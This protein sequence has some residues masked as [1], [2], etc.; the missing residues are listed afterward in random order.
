MKKF[1]TAVASLLLLVISGCKKDDS[2]PDLPLKVEF[3][4]APLEEIYCDAAVLKVWVSVKNAGS[5]DIKGCFYYG[6]SDEDLATKG[7]KVEP[8]T[9]SVSDGT[10]SALV[11]GLDS[12]TTY[13]Y[14]AELKI[15]N[16]VFL[17]GVSSFNTGRLTISVTTLPADGVDYVEATLR[18]KVNLNSK[19]IVPTNCG[20]KISSNVSTLDEV[21]ALGSQGEVEPDKDNTFNQFLNWFSADKTYHYVAFAEVDGQTYYGELVDFTTKKYAEVVSTVTAKTDKPGFVELLGYIN[22]DQSGNALGDGFLF[23]DT[24]TDL[25]SLKTS[26]TDI[27]VNH[28]NASIKQFSSRQT[29]FKDGTY[30]YA[31]YAIING[32]PYYGE[33]KSV[34]VKGVTQGDYIDMGGKVKWAAKDLGA[35]SVTDAGTFYA[36]GETDTKTT[37]SWNNYE[38]GGY[39]NITKYNGS[40]GKTVLDSEDDVVRKVLGGNYRMATL[41]EWMELV[42]NC[43]FEYSS[44]GDL[45]GKVAV[46]RINSNIMFF[47]YYGSYENDSQIAQ[48]SEWRTWTSDGAKEFQSIPYG[49]SWSGFMQNSTASAQLVQRC[50]GLP[51]RPVEPK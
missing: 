26:G 3:I 18:G 36:W 11:K 1:F 38:W 17:S 12:E 42:N 13:Y 25:E 49:F 14:M 50:Y 27:H 23:S 40:D 20:F 34:Y 24:A 32:A 48:T 37:F 7:T 28:Y 10:V 6:T 19:S 30:H 21:S 15:G 35:T 46:S 33:V 31:A 16:K 44:V 4:D 22:G 5:S 39:S 29:V 45:R 8:D 51:V 9:I 47:P 2:K 41:D 43:K